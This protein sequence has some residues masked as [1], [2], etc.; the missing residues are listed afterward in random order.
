MPIAESPHVRHSFQYGHERQA[1]QRCVRRGLDRGDAGPGAAADGSRYSRLG[2]GRLRR[3]GHA[4]PGTRR[5]PDIRRDA[6]REGRGPCPS[7]QDC[8]RLRGALETAGSRTAGRATNP[9]MGG[10]GD[11]AAARLGKPVTLR[12]IL[13]RAEPGVSAPHPIRPR[14]SLREL[15]WENSPSWRRCRT[16]RQR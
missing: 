2:G 13:A 15:T 4:L 14:R 7:V 10:D 3:R 16:Y 8:A 6:C 11:V 9:E 5:R 12:P 1:W